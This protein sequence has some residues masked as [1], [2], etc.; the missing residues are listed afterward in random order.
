MDIG[1][2]SG[3]ADIIFV[4]LDSGGDGAVAIDEFVRKFGYGRPRGEGAQP[5]PEG[6]CAPHSTA[7]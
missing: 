4:H 1:L 6:Q 5:A 2:T 3:E 7:I